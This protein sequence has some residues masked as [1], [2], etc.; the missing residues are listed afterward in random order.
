[1]LRRYGSKAASTFEAGL[2]TRAGG[3]NAVLVLGTNRCGDHLC[4]QLWRTQAGHPP[5]QLAAPV[6]AGRPAYPGSTGSIGLL[7]FASPRD[8]YALANRWTKGARSSYTT[9][10]GRSWHAMSAV[11][12]MALTELSTT[13]DAFYG[14][15][16][17]CPTART[18]ATVCTYRLGRSRLGS[19]HWHLVNIPGAA[20]TSTGIALG[21][22]GHTVWLELQPDNKPLILKSVDGNAPFQR[23]AAP[24][25]ISVTACDL[26][27]MS[28]RT[29][30]AECPTGMLVSWFR[31]VDGGHHFTQWWETSGTG[32]SSFDPLSATV[33]FRYTGIG[34]AAP[35]TLQVTT[36]GGATFTDLHH[37]AFGSGMTA[38]FAFCDIRHGY[39]LGSYNSKR[40]SPPRSVVLYTADGGRHWRTVLGGSA[41]SAVA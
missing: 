36:N 15:F 16:V 19:D 4:L 25:L 6:S 33:A 22:A 26:Q 23:L 29:T 14:L 5:V 28:T 37:F 9:D 31:S 21:A 18:T 30:W 11:D 41:Q 17:R 7:V 38:E 3:T 32:G 8:G 20:G 1:M 10:G 13:P 24:A 27:P 40:G 39:A 12:G 35:A 2:M 34:P